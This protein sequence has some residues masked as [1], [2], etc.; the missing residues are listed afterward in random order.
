LQAGILDFWQAGYP[1]SLIASNLSCQ[2]DGKQDGWIASRLA[3]QKDRRQAVF[4]A[5][6]H[7]CLK[8]GMKDFHRE[9]PP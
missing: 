5:S 8:D 6:R 2:K 9:K 7:S 1:E 4:H 3:S